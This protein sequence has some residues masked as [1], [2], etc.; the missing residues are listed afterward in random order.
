MGWAQLKVPNGY[1]GGPK[2]DGP[3]RY[4]TVK[5]QYLISIGPFRNL[6]YNNEFSLK[7]SIVKTLSFTEERLFKSN[8]QDC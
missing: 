6:T 3:K 7:F 4:A 5:L 8:L 2:R 1:S